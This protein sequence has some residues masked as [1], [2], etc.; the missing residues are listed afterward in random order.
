MGFSRQEYWSGVPLPSP[1]HLKTYIINFLS[2]FNESYCFKEDYSQRIFFCV[3]FD[4]EIKIR[5]AK[6]RWKMFQDGRSIL[7][8]KFKLDP[9]RNKSVFRNKS[10]QKQSPCMKTI[11]DKRLNGLYIIESIT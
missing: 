3:S 8:S 11:A 7:R 5:D 1:I 2:L 9:N 4:P 10:D 6:T